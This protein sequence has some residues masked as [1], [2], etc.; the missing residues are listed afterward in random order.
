MRIVFDIGGTK[1]RMARSPDNKTI[2]NIVNFPTL[3]NFDEGISDLVRHIEL[4]S[5]GRQLECISGGIAAIL[6]NDHSDVEYSANLPGWAG[7]KLAKH[8]KDIFRCEVFLHN[9]AAL[10]A[11]GEAAYGPGAEFDSFIYMT[12]GTGV[13]GAWI[14]DGK[15][16]NAADSFEP[17]HQ[18]IDLSGPACPSC[19]QPGHLEAFISGTAIK[20]RYG[21]VASEITD[22]KQI[23]ELENY[24]VVGL[25]NTYMHWPSEGVILG[26]GAALHTS[27]SM[28]RI[29]KKLKTRLG[30]YQHSPKVKLAKLGDEAGLYGAL[31][32]PT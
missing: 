11:M 7:H 29:E 23:D 4:L 31:Q 22:D 19:K 16:P 28:E 9:D 17:G 8:L 24:L 13:G 26:G 1:T 30:I 2:E 15:L 32:L 12:I 20:S 14:V 18:T 3:K 21:K 27:W 6:N 25:A 5:E 10:A